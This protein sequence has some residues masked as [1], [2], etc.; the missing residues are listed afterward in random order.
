MALPEPDTSEADVHAF[1]SLFAGKADAVQQGRVTEWI[2][3][4]SGMR[5]TP[6]FLGSDAD[7]LTYVLIGMHR[8]GTMIAN[9]ADPAT[10]AAAQAADAAKLKAPPATRR[11]TTRRGR[12]G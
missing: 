3:H 12:N 1:R 9:M 5:G 10:L 11:L 7:R 4:N 6:L 8:L 2:I